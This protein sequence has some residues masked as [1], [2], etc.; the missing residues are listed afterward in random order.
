MHLEQPEAPRSSLISWLVLI[1]LGACV[2]SGLLV[3]AVRSG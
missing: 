1:L 3:L 2:V